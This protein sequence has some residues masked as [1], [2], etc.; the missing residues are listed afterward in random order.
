ML[1]GGGGLERRM[2]ATRGQSRGRQNELERPE[3]ASRGRGGG[4][5]GGGAEGRKED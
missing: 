5:S 2:L 3:G 1:R 4:G